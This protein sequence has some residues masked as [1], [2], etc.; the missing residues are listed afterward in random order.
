MTRVSLLLLALHTAGLWSAA[1]LPPGT[2]PD[3][4]T[5]TAS[6][7]Q[8][9]Y[10]TT[11]VDNKTC[12]TAPSIFFQSI[13]TDWLGGTARRARRLLAVHAALS[14]LVP[15]P[16]PSSVAARAWHG[17]DLDPGPAV[18]PPLGAGWSVRPSL[19]SPS[20]HLHN[21]SVHHPPSTGHAEQ[22]P[23][24]AVAVVVSSTIPCPS[25]AT[26]RP[27]RGVPAWLRLAERFLMELLTHGVHR[28]RR[29]NAKVSLQASPR[30][31]RAERAQRAQ[32]A[33]R[34]QRLERDSK[35]RSLRERPRA[36]PLCHLVKLY[37]K[38]RDPIYEWDCFHWPCQSQLAH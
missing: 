25:G 17:R 19:L 36:Y 2:R 9:P 22:L 31:R 14:P 15:R 35:Q 5:L 24:R 26:H 4:S 37:R 23:E 38:R 11:L 30:A 27:W 13:N 29:R 18:D 20:P 6:S 7:S 28:G 32:R 16:P 8:I 12:H 21:F 10:A 3:R 1:W 33:E 34:A